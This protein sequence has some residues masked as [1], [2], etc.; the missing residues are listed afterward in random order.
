MPGKEELVLVYLGSQHKCVER[1]VRPEFPDYLF[2]MTMFQL[3]FRYC[4]ADGDFLG[5]FSSGDKSCD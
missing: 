3:I 1:P 2:L 5:C 4:S